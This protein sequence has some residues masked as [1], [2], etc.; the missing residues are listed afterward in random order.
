MPIAYRL[1]IKT[2]ISFPGY[3]GGWNPKE[4]QSEYIFFLGAWF[5]AIIIC[6]RSLLS[7]Q[8]FL[9]KSI[10]KI[11]PDMTQEIDSIKL[12][13]MQSLTLILKNPKYFQN[14][15]I[16]R[17]LKEL[18]FLELFT[19]TIA[20]SP[21]IL[22]PIIYILRPTQMNKIEYYKIALEAGAI[23]YLVLLVGFILCTNFFNAQ[24]LNTSK[25]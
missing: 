1:I 12:K 24:K 14:P 11:M 20:L 17:M 4:L 16:R 18:K 23:G 25:S 22:S 10:K 21:F 3:V 6:Q 9:I 19:L 2:V 13:Q 5:L 7:S 8:L 15:I